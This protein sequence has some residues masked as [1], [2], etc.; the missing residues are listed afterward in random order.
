MK[1]RRLAI[2]TFMLVAFLLLGVG[3]AAVSR[4]LQIS[5]S[6]HISA[7]TLSEFDVTFLETYS[8]NPSVNVSG[9]TAPKVDTSTVAAGG[10]EINLSVT[11]FE[12]VGDTLVITY[13]VSYSTVK[14][15]IHA[16]LS[17][18][19]VVISNTTNPS[20]ETDYFAVNAE[21]ADEYLSNETVESLTT[22]LTITIE[23]EAVPVE[24]TFIGITITFKADPASG[25]V[26]A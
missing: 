11:G 24:A 2:V 4:Q 7:V 17:E 1:N 6:A 22:T 5:G 10:H 8:Q 15:G 18:P 23:L 21:F 16:H 20:D 14:E 12:T 13:T 3:Y 26:H 9:E 19:V 25:D